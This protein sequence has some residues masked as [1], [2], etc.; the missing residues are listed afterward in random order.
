M[1]REA[2][3]RVLIGSP[4]EQQHVDR[5]A[6]VDPCIEVLYAPHLLPVPRYQADHVGTSRQ[7]TD[8]QLDQ[9]LSLL[10]AAHVS[11]DFD[12]YAPAGMPG[13]CPDLRWV[14]ATSSGIGQFLQRTELDRTEIIFTKAA[15]VHAV[16]L[17]EFAL[18]GV[19]H[20]V[21]GL[22]AIATRQAA[23]H[24]ERY[25][26]R[27]LAGRRV[28]IVGL[29]QI[30][31]KVAEV[32]TAM[33]VEVWGAARD[34]HSVDAPSVS[35]IVELAS[36]DELLPEVDAIVLCC[37]LTPQTQGLLDKRR[38]GLLPAGAI[39]VNIARGP[40]IEEAA[41]IEALADGHLGGACLDV[42][43]V[44][45]LP[46]DSPLWGMPNVIISPHSASTV[47]VENAI[48]TDLFCD[49]LHRWLNGQPLRNLY[50]NEKGY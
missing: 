49:N 11:F 31:R 28:M 8:G 44:E 4:L 27:Q 32:F 23:R 37:P 21:K 7:L 13:N 24:W 15:G 14:Q 45:P 48:L 5:I 2:T 19:L 39:V 40:V 46:E 42:V 38:L 12:W 18:T 35:K 6:A 22:P 9:W 20:F 17:A 33:G 50:S 25:T 3:L 36:M 41:L 26:T 43:T 16:P 47:D 29:G 1:S 34:P 30:G 10:S